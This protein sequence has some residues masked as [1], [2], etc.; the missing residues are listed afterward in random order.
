MPLNRISETDLQAYKNDLSD[1]EKSATELFS[2]LKKL[3]NRFKLNEAEFIRFKYI[4]AKKRLENDYLLKKEHWDSEISELK[5]QF[6]QLD[7]RIIAAEQK[8]KHG[9]PEDLLIMEKLITEQEAIVS[10]QEKLNLAEAE[11]IAHVRNIDIEYG[12]EQEKLSQLNTQ[13]S[14]NNNNEITPVEL[15]IDKAEKEIR[16]KSTFVAVIPILIIPLLADF[17]GSL[18]GLQKAIK[19]GHQ[20]I[21]GHYLFFIALILTEI[22]LADKIRIRISRLFAV[23]YLKDSFLKLQQSF[24]DNKAEI[25]RLEKSQQFKISDLENMID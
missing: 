18:I 8:L 24:N 21:I 22:F 4:L 13:K 9:I 12:K 6:K 19:P 1:T 14:I 3:K 10:D 25:S 23:H 5:K 15:S 20:I 16:L 11:L 7:N 17:L 2:N